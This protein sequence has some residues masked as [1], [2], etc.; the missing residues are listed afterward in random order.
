MNT[1]I[2]GLSPFIVLGSVTCILFIIKLIINQYVKRKTKKLLYITKLQNQ[3]I[4][5]DKEVKE[6]LVKLEKSKKHNDWKKEFISDMNI[7]Q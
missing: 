1:L 2:E 7:N 4:K 5:K 3:A 6:L